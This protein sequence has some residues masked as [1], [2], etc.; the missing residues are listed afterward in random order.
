MAEYTKAQVLSK[1]ASNAPDNAEGR[2]TPAK[3]REILEYL[4]DMKQ[5]AT[6]IT[7]SSTFL[8]GAATV[9]A[10]L[11]FI[12][13]NNIPLWTQ[14]AYPS[15][16]VVYYSG[17]LYRAI[18]AVGALETNPSAS[19]KWDTVESLKPAETIEVAISGTS[20][21]LSVGEIYTKTLT[22]NTTLTFINDDNALNKKFTL[23]IS[24]NYTLTLPANVKVISGSYSGS[25]ENYITIHCVYVDPENLGNN[26]YY[27]RIEQE[28]S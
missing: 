19:S 27:A 7:Y 20:V 5:L 14:K 9:G 25:A 1:I 11:D 2:I 21:D 22:T 16:Y 12:A 8:G 13:G 24:G 15:G 4:V 18:Q 17:Y 6:Y 10:A 23:I 3:L 26:K 28:E